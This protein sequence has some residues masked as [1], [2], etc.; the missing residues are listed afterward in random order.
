MRLYYR[1]HPELRSQNLKRNL[2]FDVK[3]LFTRPAG[4]KNC[5]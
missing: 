2:F 3:K 1:N 4:P 5:L